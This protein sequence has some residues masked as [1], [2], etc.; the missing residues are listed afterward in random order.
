MDGRAAFRFSLEL[1]LDNQTTNGVLNHSTPKQ[2][3]GCQRVTEEEVNRAGDTNGKRCFVMFVCFTLDTVRSVISCSKARVSSACFWLC[4]AI[5]SLNFL[6]LEPPVPGELDMVRG[7]ASTIS[8]AGYGVQGEGG[9]A[10]GGKKRRETVL[11]ELS[12][13]QRRPSEK[14]CGVM[15]GRANHTSRTEGAKVSPPPTVNPP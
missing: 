15:F 1:L 14:P 11:L 13:R 9:G 10:V 8:A 5:F 6:G 4:S 12:F 2:L 3:S 7:R